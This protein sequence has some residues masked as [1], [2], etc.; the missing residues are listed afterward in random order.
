MQ[1]GV[2]WTNLTRPE[3]AARLGDEGFTVSVTVVD[4]LLDQAGLGYR[5]PQKIKTMTRHPQ[6]N[7]QFQHIAELKRLYAKSGEPILSMDVKRR[8]ILGDY[9]RSG[10]VLC[11]APLSAWDH[12][13]PTHSRGAVVPH[14]IYDPQLNEGYVHLG[15]SHDTSA[16]AGD[17]L[18]DYWRCYGCRR[19]PQAETLLLLCDAG[20]SN[21]C[22]RL[23]F[24]EELGRVADLTGLCIRVAHFPTGCSKYNPIEHR[25]FPHLTRVCQGVLLR[26]LE[27]VRQLMR[28]AKTATGLRTFVR[29]LRRTY[30]TGRKSIVAAADQLCL[31]FD[32]I[33]PE[34]N[35]VVFPKEIW[36][37]I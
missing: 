28:K 5:K 9:A 33:I 23:Q 13:F 1:E 24:K 26:S 17:C 30:E 15:A 10:R 2:R 3:I 14:G 7:A 20:G 11:S 6:R 22:R 12:D 8:E 27:Q 4:R 21:G 18:L 19:Y 37:V 16:F 36:E 29:T 31:A 34:W 32:E 35:Y 25:L